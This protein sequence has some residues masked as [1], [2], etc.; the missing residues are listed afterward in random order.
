MD[1]A[2]LDSNDQIYESL[3]AIHVFALAH[4]LKRPII[5]V[6]DTVGTRK[7]ETYSQY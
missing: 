6:S 4:V 2:S 7:K 3:E 5:V 1:D